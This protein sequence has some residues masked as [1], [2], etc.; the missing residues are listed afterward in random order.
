M[1]WS[2]SAGPAKL[3][4]HYLEALHLKPDF[5][6][7]YLNLASAYSQTNQAPEAIAAVEKA[8]ELARSQGQTEMAG[9]IEDWLN[10]HRS[11]L[12]DLPKE[13]ASSNTAPPSP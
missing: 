2:K 1:H 3:F 11:S 7:V 10:S 9:Q 6:K 8:L 5:A 13:P 12:P 4:T